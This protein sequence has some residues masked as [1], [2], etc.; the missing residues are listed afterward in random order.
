MTSTKYQI[1][2]NIQSLNIQNCFGH[3]PAQSSIGMAGRFDN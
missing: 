2:L 3:P 1:N